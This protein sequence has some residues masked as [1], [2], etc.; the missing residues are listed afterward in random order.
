MSS[1][2]TTTINPPA[3]PKTGKTATAKTSDNLAATDTFL[4]RHLGPNA[5]E[6]DE[7]ARVTGFDSLDALVDATVPA[8]IRLGRALN[9]PAPKGEHE[10]L[11][12]LREIGKKNKVF[13]SF[14]GTGYHGCITPP[15]IQ[16]NIFENPGWYA[17]PTRRTRLKSRRAAWRRC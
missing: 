12:E 2:G 1:L 16:R 3:A 8:G 10:A 17:W 7:M 9:L 6:V 11:Q 13:R 15:V 4:N 14:I 5:G